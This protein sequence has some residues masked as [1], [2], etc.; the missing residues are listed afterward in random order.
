MSTQYRV[1]R[2]DTLAEPVGMASIIY[3]GSSKREATQVMLDAEL[4]LDKWEQPN[5]RYGVVVFEWY[6]LGKRYV[7]ISWR[8]IQTGG[9]K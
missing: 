9:T 8:G 5:D 1:V 7:P 4:G 2:A 3:L 6:D